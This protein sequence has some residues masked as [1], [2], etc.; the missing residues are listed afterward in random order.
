MKPY[1][2]RL[3]LTRSSLAMMVKGALP[4]TIATAIYQSPAVASVYGNFGFL[5]TVASIL[6]MQLLPRARFLQN[7]ALGTVIQSSPSHK[8][9]TFAHSS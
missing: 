1:L 5:I 2:Q 6:S 3:G 7:V 4:A 9:S 8:D